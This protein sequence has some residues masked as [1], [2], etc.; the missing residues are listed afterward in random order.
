MFYRL[1]QNLVVIVSIVKRHVPVSVGDVVVTRV[2]VVELFLQAQLWCRIYDLDLLFQIHLAARL[3]RQ[4][5][6]CY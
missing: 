1:L 3:E 4:K 2:K 6:H 5:L